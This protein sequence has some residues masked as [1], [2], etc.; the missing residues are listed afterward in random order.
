MKKKHSVLIVDDEKSLREALK[1]GLTGRY[2]VFEA[3]NGLSAL[4]AIAKNDIEVVLLDIKLPNDSGIDLLEKIK[5]ADGSIN[6]IMVTGDNT[7]GSA[8]RSM[9]LGAYDYLTKP[10]DINELDLLVSKA[11]K[12]AG[13]S[14]RRTEL[15]P[16]GYM[17]SKKI[18]GES[19]KTKGLL[20]TIGQVAPLDST[21]L[22]CGET[23]T[24][25][26]LVAREI[27]QRSRRSG[28]PFI[29]VNCAAVPEN[30]LESELFGHEKGSFTGAFERHIGKFESANYGTL[31]LDEVGS[32]PAAMQGKLLRVL[33]DRMIERVGSD[34]PVPID[35]RLLSA[36]NIDLKKAI[37]Q[38]KFREDLYFRLNVIPVT[39]PPLRERKED[40]KA[41][42]AHFIKRMNRILKTSVRGLSK[43]AFLI[44]SDYDWPGNVRELENLIERMVVLCRGKL[45]T[46]ND[47]PIEI[48]G[49]SSVSE[50][51][52]VRSLNLKQATTRFEKD[53]ILNVIEKAR[54]KKGKAAKILGIH[55]NTLL[56]LEKK[57]KSE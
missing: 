52:S 18:I 47:I 15:R 17:E 54:G 55:R 44:L 12:Q 11:M 4:D 21:I 42:C 40:M 53:F 13:V 7:A 8:V 32:L 5:K 6:I 14:K 26:E 50:I 23:G 34:K 39:V 27:H 57:L 30:L 37:E 46:E 22:I 41:L 24:G 38:G 49:R 9:K 29:P 45:I 28:K 16:V 31:F 43:K 1:M 20:K 3:S 36:T 2:E 56:K 25:K 10:F 35:I 48:A 33:Q 51:N 19:E